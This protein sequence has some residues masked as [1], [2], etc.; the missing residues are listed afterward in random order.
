ML[1]QQTNNV[2][3]RSSNQSIDHARITTK[4]MLWTTKKIA[5]GVKNHKAWFV[6]RSVVFVLFWVHSRTFV[7]VDVI[8]TF[9]HTEWILQFFFHPHLFWTI[10][11]FPNEAHCAAHLH[12]ILSFS[13]QFRSSCRYVPLFDVYQVRMGR[14][15]PSLRPEFAA[16]ANGEE[17]SSFKVWSK[18]PM[19]LWWIKWVFFDQRPRKSEVHGS[20]F[21]WNRIL[22]CSLSN[23]CQ[24]SRN[25]LP[26]RTVS[27][28]LVDCS[29]LFA[30]S[31]DRTVHSWGVH[32]CWRHR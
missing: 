6:D 15:G 24:R 31:W 32:W 13:A 28:W 14:K 26:L 25:C 16:Q 4:Q 3:D 29:F 18:S 8:L 2:G 21:P 22:L 7:W 1:T 23:T 11:S 12:R 27:S 30:V 20:G 17:L 19:Q 10:H 5:I 9:T